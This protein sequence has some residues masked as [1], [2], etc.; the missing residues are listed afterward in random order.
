MNEL[1]NETKAKKS[2][3]HSWIMLKLTQKRAVTPNKRSTSP[4]AVHWSKYAHEAI[5]KTCPDGTLNL[6]VEGGS[7]NGEFA[8][9]GHVNLRLVSLIKGE[10]EKGEIILEIQGQKLAG[11]TQRDVVSWLNHC[12]RNGNPVNLQLA[13]QGKLWRNARRQH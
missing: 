12:C 10:L 6:S 1:Q 2:T 8:Y 13:P 7:D 9:L 11:Y 3:T 5:I 4:I